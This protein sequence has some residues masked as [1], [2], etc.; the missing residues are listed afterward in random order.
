[1]VVTREETER[2]ELIEAGLGILVGTDPKK[3]IE[4]TQFFLSSKPLENQKN[5]FGDGLAGYRIVEILHHQLKT[6]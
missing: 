2:P 5:P 1:V 4:A 3:I 6:T